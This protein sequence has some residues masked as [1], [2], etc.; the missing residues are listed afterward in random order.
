MKHKGFTLIELLVVMAVIA[1]LIAILLPVLRIAKEQARSA[2]C[3]SNIR[4]IFL[5]L[6]GYENENDI[7]PFS[8][9]DK[10]PH[11]MQNPPGGY[12][13]VHSYDKV[14]WWWFHR[15]IDYTGKD[16]HNEPVIR[17]PS[18]SIEGS[19]I[20]EN[21][22]CG[23]YGVNRSICKSA[24]GKGEHEEFNGKPLGIAQISRPSETLLLSD[25][26]YASVI[27]WHVTDSP[28]SPLSDNREDRAGY[29][30]G[31][32]INGLR[33]LELESGHRQ[34]AI[35]GRH[36]NKTVNVGFVDGHIEHVNAN[37]LY[38]ERVGSNYKNRS[39]LW[40]PK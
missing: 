10:P 21:P 3:C 2:V 7:F 29:I 37:D 36:R 19:R 26:G 20:R 40:R 13:G 38:V 27:W 35:G 31:L 16:F 30:P 8:F 22:L 4:Q 28:P 23:N 25:C 33:P 6:S 1:V 12:V 32:W 17:C 11:D 15:T 24:R 5:G 18:R 34:D 9:D 14:G 39:P